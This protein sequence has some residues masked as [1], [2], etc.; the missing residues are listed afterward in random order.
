[1]SVETQAILFDVPGPKALKRIKLFNIAG[2][3]LGLALVGGILWLLYVRGQL[4]ASKWV[5]LVQWDS[6]AYYFLPGLWATIKASIFAVIGSVIF[7]LVFGVGRLSHHFWVR[8]PCSI[9]VEFLRAV[10][11]LLMMVFIYLYLGYGG[12]TDIEDKG[13]VAVV[14]ALIFYNGSVV[15]ELVRSGV[16]SLPRGQAEASAAIG[17]TRFKS[18]IHVEVPQALL[19]MLPALVAQLVVVLKDSALGYMVG[20]QELLRSSQRL[21]T[22]SGQANTIQTMLMATVLFLVINYALSRLADW[23][24]I[25]L[26]GRSRPQPEELPASVSVDAELAVAEATVWPVST[27]PADHTRGHHP[28]PPEA[29]SREPV[30]EMWVKP[31]PDPPSS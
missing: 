14:V 12:F 27:D 2:A 20:Y 22:T 17:L 18:L 21:G 4:E 1:M 28:D 8:W 31:D 11:V 13:L 7:G 25:R 10:P 15:A 30:R 24:G 26:R 23:L 3:I 19:A 29:E 16:H 9:V 5:V 6:W